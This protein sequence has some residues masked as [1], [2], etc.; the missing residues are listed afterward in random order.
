MTKPKVQARNLSLW[1]A[2]MIEAFAGGF[3]G[4]LFILAAAS[5]SILRCVRAA[6]RKAIRD[7]CHDN[8]S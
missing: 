8:R 6:A 4:E 1:E 5:D 7:L 3:S 2:D